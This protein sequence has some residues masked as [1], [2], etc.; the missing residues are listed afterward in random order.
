MTIIITMPNKSTWCMVQGPSSQAMLLRVENS[1]TSTGMKRKTR[2]CGLTAI[3]VLVPRAM[4]NSA[5]VLEVSSFLV[6]G[7]GAGR[8]EQLELWNAWN[9]R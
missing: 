9:L 4:W 1:Q 5:K 8:L 6:C 2:D 7:S 3:D